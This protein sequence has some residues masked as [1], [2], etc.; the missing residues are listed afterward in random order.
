[1][2]TRVLPFA[3]PPRVRPRQHEIS[4]LHAK[5]NATNGPPTAH[6]V[7]DKPRYERLCVLATSCPLVVCWPLIVCLVP[8]HIASAFICAGA[9]GTI[10]PLS[11][12]HSVSLSH[13]KHPSATPSASSDADAG[14][15]GLTKEQY[16]PT[17]RNVLAI[18]G[19]RQCNH[20]TT[21]TKHARADTRGRC[22]HTE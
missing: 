7:T 8:L 22:I 14:N 21:G 3:V 19:V 12:H 18:E 10:F 4:I 5:K 11:P 9:M 17:K 16:G 13:P 6:A 20:S 2:G 1:M 15:V